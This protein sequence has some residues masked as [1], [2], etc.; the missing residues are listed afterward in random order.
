MT[1]L[2]QLSSNKLVVFGLIVVVLVLIGAVC[3]PLF[4]TADPNEIDFQSRLQP[5]SAG[6]WF[7][8]DELGRDLWAR[9]LYGGRVSVS[10]AVI[11]ATLAATAGL[12]IGAVSG[13]LGGR[14]DTF[15]MRMVD[16]L[17]AIPGLVL[18]MA[19]TAALGPS[20][21]NAMFALAFVAMP[22][23]IRLVRGQA[24][25]VS[26]AGYTEAAGS[27]GAGRT[28]VVR[29]HVIPYCL[30]IVLVQITL[31][32]GALILAAAA[33]SFL[34]LGAQPP[35]AEWGAMVAAGRQY[36]MTH[37]WYPTIPGLAILVTAVGFN[38]IGDGLRDWLDTR[39]SAN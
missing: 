4:A 14:V 24:R 10:I 26:H 11:V 33:L 2:R 23:Y 38:L 19:L 25:V 39:R 8:T 7:G 9:V 30:P 1:S 20:L 36:L 6:H 3:A 32:I 29:V 37:W 27:F 16:I 15:I 34:G 35:T 28:Y 31:D 21:Q 18:A 12:I 17:I 13:Y 5:P 22:G